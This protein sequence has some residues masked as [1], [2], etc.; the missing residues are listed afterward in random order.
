[1]GQWDMWKCE[2]KFVLVENHGELT[3]ETLLV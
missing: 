1:M 3:I 2:L